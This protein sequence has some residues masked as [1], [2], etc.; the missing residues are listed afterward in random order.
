[1]DRDLLQV[2]IVLLALE[3]V[4]RIL[5]VLGGDVAGDARYAAGLLLSALEDDL[6]PVSFSLLCHSLKN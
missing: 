4:R 3:A 1:M 6:H 5:L 2:R